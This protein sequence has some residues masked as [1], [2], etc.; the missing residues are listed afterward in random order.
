[1]SKQRAKGT[2]YESA[3][4]GYLRD[5]GFLRAD[6][7]GSANFGAGDISGVPGLV[8]EAKNQI[9]LD[10]S[11]WVNQVTEARD[12]TDSGA[13]PVVFHKRR[14]K[15]VS[16]SYVTISLDEFLSLITKSLTP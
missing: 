6:R 12:R 14:G 5:R 16:K 11:G 15:H 9:S 1:V 4:V 13:I 8:I 7:T 10:L 2:S 3:L